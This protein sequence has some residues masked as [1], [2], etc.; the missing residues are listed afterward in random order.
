MK[1]QQVFTVASKAFWVTLQSPMKTLGEFIFQ[2]SFNSERVAHGR[3]HKHWHEFL[4]IQQAQ[5][6]GKISTRVT[7]TAKTL[8]LR[9]QH[10][11]AETKSDGHKSLCNDLSAICALV[12]EASRGLWRKWAAKHYYYYSLV[13]II[14]PILIPVTGV[15]KKK[16]KIR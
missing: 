1:H 13:A 7:G 12:C 16:E 6:P 9:S 2:L 4:Q 5:K 3:L 11:A 10:R 8:R 14:T 15:R